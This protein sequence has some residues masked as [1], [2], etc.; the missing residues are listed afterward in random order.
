[1]APG[2][3]CHVCHGRFERSGFVDC[4]N[5]GTTFHEECFEFHDTYECEDADEPAIG[6]V[7]L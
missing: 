6:A 2:D 4:P 5:C 3:K 1:M 7:E